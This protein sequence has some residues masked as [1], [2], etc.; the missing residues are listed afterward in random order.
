MGPQSPSNSGRQ[1]KVMPISISAWR[2]KPLT[3]KVKELGDMLLSDTMESYGAPYGSTVT[4]VETVA[5]PIHKTVLTCT[6]TPLVLT[7]ESGTVV[8]G[9]VQVYT[10]PA[11]RSA[12]WARPCRERSRP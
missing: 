2:T 9:G 1:V 6:A 5:G 4:A 3:R 8:Y 10:F 12:S 7:D 11:G